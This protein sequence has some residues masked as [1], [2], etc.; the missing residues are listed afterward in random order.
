[1]RFIKIFFGFYWINV[2]DVSDLP[3]DQWR[4]HRNTDHRSRSR[5]RK[6]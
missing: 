6:I 1:M 5:S 2:R 3:L 4:K